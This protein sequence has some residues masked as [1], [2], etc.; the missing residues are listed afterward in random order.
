MLDFDIDDR[1]RRGKVGWLQNEWFLD[2]I[3]VVLDQSMVVIL[4]YDHIGAGT[5]ES[6]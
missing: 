4:I 1:L 5:G 2:G 3:N 6:T